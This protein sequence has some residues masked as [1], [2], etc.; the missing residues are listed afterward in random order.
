M[1]FDPL[2]IITAMG[3]QCE[4][5]PLKTHVPG[6]SQCAET[7]PRATASA[8]IAA[9][10]QFL[11]QQF[12]ARFRGK[13]A[14]DEATVMARVTYLLLTADAFDVDLPFTIVRARGD[15]L[16]SVTPLSI[17]ALLRNTESQ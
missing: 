14:A 5:S 3:V 12:S 7:N 17:E 6:A 1:L 9:I 10:A 8:D 15:A 2:C 4:S 13:Q 16:K 11:T